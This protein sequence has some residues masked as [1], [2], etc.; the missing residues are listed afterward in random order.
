[1]L[2]LKLPIE[3]LKTEVQLVKKLFIENSTKIYS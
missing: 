1:M 3:Y 2:P